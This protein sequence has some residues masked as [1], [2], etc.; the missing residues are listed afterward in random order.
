M[1]IF[2]E[3]GEIRFQLMD[4]EKGIM[5]FDFTIEDDKEVYNDLKE[6]IITNLQGFTP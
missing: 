3:N 6:H 5:L 4:L 2:K 1:K